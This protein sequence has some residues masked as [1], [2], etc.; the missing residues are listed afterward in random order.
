[1]PGEIELRPIG[2]MARIE[3]NEYVKYL[4]KSI[5]EQHFEMLRLKDVLRKKREETKER[6]LDPYKI[7]FSMIRVE[8]QIPVHEMPK[9]QK[10]YLYYLILF[11][12]FKHGF[13]SS[14]EFHSS[15][16]R[17]Y[18]I[19]SHTNVVRMLAKMEEYG[20]LSL[21]KQYKKFKVYNITEKGRVY[22]DKIGGLIAQ[23][24]EPIKVKT[25]NANLWRKRKA[26]QDPKDG[27]GVAERQE[28]EVSENRDT[29][30]I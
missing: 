8:Q 12:T 30:D 9:R 13:I 4:H 10:K 5:K 16:Y 28:A 22:A 19:P 27:A 7:L 6:K 18:A 23:Y 20:L 11:H 17:R 2:K 25:G 29:E 14:S 26:T 24:F 1:M 3:L 15:R 21:F